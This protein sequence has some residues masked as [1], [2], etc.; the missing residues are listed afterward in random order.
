MKLGEQSVGSNG[1][2]ANG[3]TTRIS[4]EEVNRKVDSYRSDFIRVTGDIR[5][6]FRANRSSMDGLNARMD[7]IGTRLW[8]IAS[9]ILAA[10][11]YFNHYHSGP[12]TNA[13][14]TISIEQAV[15]EAKLE[16]ATRQEASNGQREEVTSSPIE[17]TG[18]GFVKDLSQTR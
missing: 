14:K 7:T 3:D 13:Q 18:T 6:E 9:V 10:V 4:T 15:K 2:E 11:T 16:E 12:S 17:F 8:I 1:D 5:Q